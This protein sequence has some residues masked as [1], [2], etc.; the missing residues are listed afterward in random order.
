MDIIKA[1]SKERL[2]VI[3][4]HETELAKSYASR[5]IEIQDRKN[6]KRLFK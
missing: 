5:I 4:T 6:H 1:I 2:V 3:V